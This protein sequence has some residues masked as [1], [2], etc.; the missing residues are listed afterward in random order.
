M[1]TVGAPA[2]ELSLLQVSFH[3]SRSRNLQVV[4]IM[5]RTSLVPSSARLLSL[6]ALSFDPTTS[7]ATK[8]FCFAAYPTKITYESL[9]IRRQPLPLAS[10]QL[11]AGGCDKYSQIQPT[12]D[13]HRYGLRKPPRLR[14]MQPIK[15]CSIRHYSNLRDHHINSPRE[16]HQQ[17]Q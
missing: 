10:A 3:L 2:T 15:H 14:H 9:R 13:Q 11:S 6:D 4:S 1:S 8:F 17:V 12:E 5:V 7:V 16:N